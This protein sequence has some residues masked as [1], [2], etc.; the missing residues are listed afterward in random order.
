MVRGE[1]GGYQ[2]AVSAYIIIK[3]V[4]SENDG[5]DRLSEKE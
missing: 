5:P 1:G 2:D 3:V 4:W